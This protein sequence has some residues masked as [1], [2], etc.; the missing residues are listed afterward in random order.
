MNYV[1]VGSYLWT[2]LDGIIKDEGLH[3]YDIEKNGRDSLRVFV[4]GSSQNSDGENKSQAGVTAGDCSRLLERLVVLFTAEGSSLG[5]S[6]EPQIEVSSPGINRA[7]RLQEHFRGAIGQRLKVVV[8][9]K[10]VT[11]EKLGGSIIGK[12]VTCD[13]NKLVIEVED[14]KEEV[15]VMMSNVKKANVNFKF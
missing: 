4:S 7:L 5:F 15:E 2:T 13:Q 3:L 12:L 9:S 10:D 1:D 8:S 14:R 6:S 11:S